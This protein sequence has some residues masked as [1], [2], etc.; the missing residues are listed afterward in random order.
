MQFNS[1]AD[2]GEYLS[3]QH[4]TA[5]NLEELAPGATATTDLTVMPIEEGE[6]VLR[7]QCQADGIQAEPFEK[8]VRVDGQSELSFSI[9]DENDPIETDGQT[10]YVIKLSNVG[11]R[12]DQNVQVALE[13]PNG[14][15]VV[16]VR[17]PV[18]NSQSGSRVIF[19][20]IPEMKAKDQLVYQI[21]VKLPTEGTQVARAF[22]KSQVRQTPVVKEESTQV[23]L[24]R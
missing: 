11:T 12:A 24:D 4:A 2:Q 14:A 9:E 16:N 10:T 5:W 3:E 23:Y 22:V 20:P 8:P 15:T 21:T 19:E 7:L 13:L 6:F 1:A 18:G 17:A